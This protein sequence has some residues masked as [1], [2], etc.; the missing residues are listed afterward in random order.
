MFSKI[1]VFHKRH[2]LIFLTFFWVPLAVHNT[3]N[4]FGSDISF[5]D[6]LV[7]SVSI[8]FVIDMFLS[9]VFDLFNDAEITV[10]GDIK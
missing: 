3:A 4:I 8:S 9:R 2:Y 5:W 7:V 1:A 6:S 10:K